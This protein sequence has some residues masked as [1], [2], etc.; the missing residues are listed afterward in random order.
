[1]YYLYPLVGNISLQ[2]T[3][4][5]ISLYLLCNWNRR[6]WTFSILHRSQEYSLNCHNI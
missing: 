6:K 5:W 4:L 3:I 1:V 2:L